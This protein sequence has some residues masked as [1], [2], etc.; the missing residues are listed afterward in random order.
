MHVPV[1]FM[2]AA[3]VLIPMAMVGCQTESAPGAGAAATVSDSAGTRI[4]ENAGSGDEP[5]GTLEPVWRHGFA[6]GD[7][8]FQT[9]FFGALRGDGSAV[10]GDLGSQQVVAVDPR[11]EGHTVLARRG[12]GPS[13][14]AGLRAVVGAGGDRV[15]VEDDRN[16]KLL[17]YVGDSLATLVSTREIPEVSFGLMA[18]GVDQEG[19]LLMTTATFPSDFTEPW[20]MGSMVRFDPGTGLADT[21]G[22]FPLAARYDGGP[23]SPYSVRSVISAA[24]DGFVHGR[25]GQPEIIWQSGQGDVP[26]IARWNQEPTFPTDSLWTRFQTALRED[27]RRVNPQMGGELL[28]TF[29]N[30]QIAQYTVDPAAPLPLFGSLR[31][32]SDGGVWIAEYT[33]GSSWPTRYR[34]LAPD[35][36]WVGTIEFPGP[37]LLLSVRGDLVLGVETDELDVQGVAVYRHGFGG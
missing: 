23:W 18:E 32:T 19:R 15:W 4:V 37:F 11:G 3:A 13:E 1:G 17:L 22:A 2:R 26:R 12:Q 6:P 8:E 25:T 34:V 29:V 5:I 20:F 7:H 10:V 9:V 35:G 36:V 28:Q 33:P 21:M 14:V 27:L 24:G 16:A 30:D 31:G